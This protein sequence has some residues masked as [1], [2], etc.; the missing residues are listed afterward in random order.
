MKTNRYKKVSCPIYVPTGDY[1][2]DWESK[3]I[4]PQFDNNNGKAVC[5]ISNEYVHRVDN[6]YIKFPWCIGL[7]DWED[8]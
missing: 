2:W 4:C 3:E 7:H 5:K 1:C 8:E 6:G